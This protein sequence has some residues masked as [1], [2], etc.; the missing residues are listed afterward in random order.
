MDATSLLTWVR[1]EAI[2]ALGSDVNRWLRLIDVARAN[3]MRSRSLDSRT[4]FRE[5][6]LMVLGQAQRLGVLSPFE[7]VRRNLSLRARYMRQGNFDESWLRQEASSIFKLLTDSIPIEFAA[8][9]RLV[10]RRRSRESWIATD[11]EARDSLDQLVELLMPVSHTLY[12]L[13]PRDR[14]TIE[15]WMNLMSKYM[16]KK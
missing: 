10:E 6:A 12:Y 5:A 1:S 15:P 9:S 11:P 13:E 16:D 7:S 3:A 14:A 2:D 4:D 8:A